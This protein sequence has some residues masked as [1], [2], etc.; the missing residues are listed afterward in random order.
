MKDNFGSFQLSGF[1]LKEKEFL[2]K[3]SELNPCTTVRA[4]R[5]GVR[6]GILEYQ[7]QC[8]EGGENFLK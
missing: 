4:T 8:E 1:R 6:L 5:K 3:S 2:P 7:H